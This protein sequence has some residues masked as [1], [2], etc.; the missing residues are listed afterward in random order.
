[1]NIPKSYSV[2][3]VVFGTNLLSEVIQLDVYKPIDEE[4][5]N[6]IEKTID[7]FKLDQTKML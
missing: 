7:R 1:M 4:I 3:L 5:L 6:K 2:Y